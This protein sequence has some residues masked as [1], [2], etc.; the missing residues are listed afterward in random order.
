MSDGSAAVLVN[1]GGTEV[2]TAGNPLRTEPAGSTAQ[3]VTATSLP[4]P[5]G[6]ATSVK[7]PAIGTAGTPSADVIS[8]QG[9][10]GGDPLATKEA[11]AS[12]AVVTSVAAAVADTVLLAQN[13]NRMGASV[14]NDG[15]AM[16]YLKL[17]T[18]ASTT[19]HTVQLPRGG[20]YEIPFGYTGPINGYWS[21]AIGNA[22]VTEVTQ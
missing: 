11:R 17:G 3:P 13:Q 7:Q 5:T 6:A 22:R 20:Y 14:T 1:S 9:V 21:A 19:S 18:G 4:L 16:L 12:N 8:V 15:V 10:S 2:G